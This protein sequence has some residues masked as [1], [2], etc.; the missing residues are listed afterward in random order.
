MGC[1]ECLSKC[2]LIVFVTWF[3][4]DWY[5]SSNKS[6]C[7]YSL[8]VNMIT[9]IAFIRLL[10][11]YPWQTPLVH[12]GIIFTSDCHVVTW[13]LQ[14]KHIWR[15]V[16][17]HIFLAQNITKR[18]SSC[19]VSAVPYICMIETHGLPP[20]QFTSCWLFMWQHGLSR[21]VVA[22]DLVPTWRQLINAH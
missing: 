19:H 10:W 11:N 7:L 21:M 6:F 14:V 12:I 16:R 17:T 1:M 3:S 15:S 4:G 20:S 5:W 18:A 22:D 9:F 13:C 8:C 2:S